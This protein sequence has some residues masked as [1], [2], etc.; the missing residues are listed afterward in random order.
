MSEHDVPQGTPQFAVTMRGYDRLQ[1]DDYV[2]TLSGYLTEAQ[3]RALDAE[4][5]AVSLADRLR[6]L[7][8]TATLETHGTG[9][10]PPVGEPD[11]IA[12]EPVADEVA[13][14]VR[15]TLTAA[16]ELAGR[17]RG[18]AVADRESARRLVEQAEGEARARAA[19]IIEQA[20]QTVER[21]SRRAQLERT[22]RDD[23]R[24]Q[25]AGLR[26]LL[27]DLGFET[28]SQELPLPTVSAAP[29]AEDAPVEDA[30]AEERTVLMQLPQPS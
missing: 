9:G 29:P 13:T 8:S 1:V 3:A 27:E 23:V 22:R 26:A 5:A 7:E 12:R 30:P 20:Q 11:P 19:E 10:P 4:D 18:E 17:L 24:R 14:A 6:A 28:G 15:A 25:L 16:E 2:A 21:L